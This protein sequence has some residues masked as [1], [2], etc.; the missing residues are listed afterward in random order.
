M[1]PYFVKRTE[2]A[3]W[4]VGFNKPNGD[5]YAT[6]DHTSQA[7]AFEQ[8]EKLNGA[9]Y[10]WVYVTSENPSANSNGLWTVGCYSNGEWRAVSDHTSEN[11]AI[12]CVIYMNTDDE[13]DT[14]DTDKP[15]DTNLTVLHVMPNKKEQT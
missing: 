11:S 6:S 14:S 7:E 1:N 9:G 5:W 10:G 15:E 2:D 12:N 3:L 4:T 13:F 8:R